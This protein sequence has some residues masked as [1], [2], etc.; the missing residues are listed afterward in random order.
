MRDE[1]PPAD[2]R[3]V[4]KP[5]DYMTAATRGSALE[6]AGL[7]KDGPVLSLD[8]FEQLRREICASGLASGG[9]DLLGMEIDFDAWLQ[10]WA[11]ADGA[12][13]LWQNM[14]VQ[15]HQGAQWL[16]T[17]RA[18]GRREDADAIGAELARIWEECLRYPYR[19]GH[20][21]ETAPDQVTLR[22]VTQMAPGGLWVSAAVQVD[23]A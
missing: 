19:A 8:D 6:R 7:R 21:V 9:D 11:D 12:P 14:V 5:A 23:L 3:Q 22:A 4:L 1:F 15:R 13:G 18:T 2:V 10:G 20:T 16:I 17:G